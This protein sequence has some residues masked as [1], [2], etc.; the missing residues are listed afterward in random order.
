MNAAPPGPPP[1]Q[2]P[3]R[4]R[5]SLA[6]AVRAAVGELRDLMRGHGPVSASP[7]LASGAF[8]FWL[9]VLCLLGVLAFRFPEYLT[10][11]MLRAAY[12]VE[13]LRQLLLASMLVSGTVAAIDLVAGRRRPLAAAA[14]ATVLGAVALGGHGVEVGD[15]REGTPYIGL[16]WFV[17]DLLM[18]VALFVLLERLLPMRA[19]QP[20]FRE[21]WQV[22]LAW[23]GL[24]HAIV[25]LV[26]LVVNRLVHAGFGA[27]VDPR[28]H[29][30]VGALPFPVALLACL[31]VADL[32]QYGMHRAM[33]AVPWLWRF[34]AI[35]HSAKRMDWLA[36]S[37]LHLLEV[38]ATR[39]AVL[40]PL[41]VL[42]FSKDVM[43]AFIVVIGLQAVMIHSN[44]RLRLG[45]IEW[46]WA[47][48]S[49]HHWH[50]ASDEVAIDRNFAVNFPLIDVVFGTAAK[51]PRGTLPQAYGLRD[52]AV[53][54]TLAGQFAWPF[55]R[56]ERPPGSR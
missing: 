22:D 12:D 51:V 9:A 8:S 2:A 53:P 28:L 4:G 17:L 55:S 7:G 49:W 42:G 50:H 44:L 26:F 21:D 45:P 19:G 16:D 30:T 37:R 46:L 24:N 35:H 47:T 52:E 15:F 29:D 6:S 11:P 27:F 40:G 1:P 34:H 18:S 56:P 54:G 41:Y 36:G 38:V 13:L 33:H 20:I 32:A 5:P 10:T 48:P 39:V 25:G 3:P 14:L 43:D 23:F 31:L